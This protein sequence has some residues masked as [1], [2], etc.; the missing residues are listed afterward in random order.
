MVYCPERYDIF[1]EEQ[2][3]LHVHG[4]HNKSQEE[5]IVTNTIEWRQSIVVYADM[6]VL[7]E[8][9]S[10]GSLDVQNGYTEEQEL[11]SVH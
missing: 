6:W 2:S 3:N 1:S 8:T 11:C 9:D 10:P 4:T 7:K 5:E